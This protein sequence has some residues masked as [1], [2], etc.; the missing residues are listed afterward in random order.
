MRGPFLLPSFSEHVRNGGGG[1]KLKSRIVSLDQAFA[2]LRIGP[3]VRLETGELVM[4]NR[5]QPLSIS[6]TV[7][8]ADGEFGGEVPE[9]GLGVIGPFD[10]EVHDKWQGLLVLVFIECLA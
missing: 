5:L 8:I 9:A 2:L 4:P 7:P 6:C 3:V 1:S 10:E